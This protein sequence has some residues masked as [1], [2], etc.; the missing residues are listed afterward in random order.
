MA[1]RYLHARIA[2]RLVPGP[3]SAWF[4][5]AAARMSL[6]SSSGD[7]AVSVLSV[8]GA[9]AISLTGVS[10]VCGKSAGIVRVEYTRHPSKK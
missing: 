8:G 6:A 2:A 4:W 9:F 5:A 7:R 3:F 1:L 10:L